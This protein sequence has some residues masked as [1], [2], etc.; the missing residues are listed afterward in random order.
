MFSLIYLYLKASKWTHAAEKL[1]L[2]QHKDLE[3]SKLPIK[4][5]WK[6]IS[7][8]MQFKSYNFTP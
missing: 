1:L 4:N 8:E 2:A 7:D 6:K 5:K 3:E